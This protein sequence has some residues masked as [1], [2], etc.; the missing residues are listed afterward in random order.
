MARDI[1]KVDKNFI[2]RTAEGEVPLRTVEFPSD[3]L[4]ISGIWYDKTHFRRVPYALCDGL[5]RGMRITGGLC[6]GAHLRFSTDSSVL[7]IAVQTDG[8]FCASHM[9]M[10][11]CCG[12]TLMEQT[13]RGE[14]FVCNFIPQKLEEKDFVIRKELNNKGERKDYILYFPVYISVWKFSLGIELNAY[15]GRGKAYKKELPI[16][17]YGSSIT[18]GLC[19]TR[20]DN[21]YPAILSKWNDIDF[22]NMGFS[23]NAHAEREMAEFLSGIECSLF[24]CDYDWNAEN[25]EALRATHYLFYKKFREGNPSVPILFISMP[26]TDWDLEVCKRRYQIIKNTYLRAKREGDERVYLLNGG[27]L[28][29][30]E[31]RENCTVDGCHPTDLGFYRMAKGVYKKIKEIDKKFE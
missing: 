18:H 22:I 8:L 14:K 3:E 26:S 16:L 11:A 5:G 10:L 31:D 20:A 15:L 9:T 29:G 2:E 13:E 30:K 23:G 12:F 7:E 27:T 24:V 4:T 19:A 1:A 17:Y 6:A 25:E 28:F 21:S